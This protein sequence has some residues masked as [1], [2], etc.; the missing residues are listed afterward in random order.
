M[1]FQVGDKVF[2]M[3][4]GHGVVTYVADAAATYPI[5]AT[6]GTGDDTDTDTY[7]AKGKNITANVAPI[8]YHKEPVI[9]DIEPER[10]PDL[11]V[12]TP[13]L[14]RLCNNKKWRK[15]HFY[16][17]GKG[18]KCVA[19]GGGGTSWSTDAHS[20]WTEW[21]PVSYTHLTLPTICSV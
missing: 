11:A 19:W 21:K 18:G 20:I 1:S 7:T 14:V 8:L 16:G 3:R 2:D 17:W 9:V 5:A 4:F 15:R 13:V 10:M 12:D 6:F